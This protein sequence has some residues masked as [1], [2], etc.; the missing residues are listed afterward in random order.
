MTVVNYNDRSRFDC[1]ADCRLLGGNYRLCRPLPLVAESENIAIS[2]GGSLSPPV[3]A[4]QKINPLSLRPLLMK[5]CGVGGGFIVG[6]AAVTST[7]SIT[8]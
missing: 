8:P 3:K 4:N 6:A 7:T 2:G 1:L 5:L